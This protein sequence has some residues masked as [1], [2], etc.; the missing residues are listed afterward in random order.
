MDVFQ[1]DQ[2]LF[3]KYRLR[4]KLAISSKVTREEYDLILQ[5]T[6]NIK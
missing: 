2:K 6:K 3:D 5:A 4:Y 1:D